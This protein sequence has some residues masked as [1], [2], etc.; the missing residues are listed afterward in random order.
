MLTTS[1]LQ[2]HTEWVLGGG[3]ERTDGL[4]VGVDVGEAHLLQAAAAVQLVVAR[5]RLLAQ[6][7]HVRADQH[8]AQLH[9]VAVRL[10]LHCGVTLWILLAHFHSTTSSPTQPRLRLPF[11]YIIFIFYF[12]LFICLFIFFSLFLYDSFSVEV[13]VCIWTWGCNLL[14]IGTSIIYLY[15]FRNELSPAVSLAV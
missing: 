4:V 7:L 13:R 2:Y 11:Y 6:V 12:F 15:W 1:Q 8:L 5:V 3:R 9:E 14:W 10:V